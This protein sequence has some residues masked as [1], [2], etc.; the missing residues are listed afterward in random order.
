VQHFLTP[1]VESL[2][3]PTPLLTRQELT[4]IFSNFID[5][6]NLHRSFFSSLS[7][8]LV[9][10]TTPTPVHLT[11]PPPPL[12]PLLLSHFHYL[13]LYTPFVTTF[14]TSIT[15]L[16][17]LL[18]QP[19]SSSPFA[20]FIHTQQLHPRCMK[21]TLRDWVAHDRPTVS[22]ISTFVEGF[23]WVYDGGGPRVRKVRG[24]SCPGFQ[25]CVLFYFI[26]I[27]PMTK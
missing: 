12:S 9:P 20:S 13:S 4:A 18:S 14:S 17:S 1:I 19:P 6:W 24:G 16:F 3:T 7:A 15:T 23:D 25:E 22:A 21:L 10:S 2:D 26:G 5:I 27:P 8:L 11:P